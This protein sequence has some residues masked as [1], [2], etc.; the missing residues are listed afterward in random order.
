MEVLPYMEITKLPY[1]EVLPY[2]NI[3]CMYILPLLVMLLYMWIPHKDLLLYVRCMFHV[4][5]P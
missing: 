1:M 5:L 2:M 3:L 4:S